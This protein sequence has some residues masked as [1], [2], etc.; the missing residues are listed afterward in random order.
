MPY[1]RWALNWSGWLGLAGMAICLN[2][3]LGATAWIWLVVA[4]LVVWVASRPQRVLNVLFALLVAGS[5][6]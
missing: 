4:P 3:G 1:L 2:F 6:N 5:T